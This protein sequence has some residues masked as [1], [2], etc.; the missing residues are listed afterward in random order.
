[1]N[2]QLDGHFRTLHL[3]LRGELVSPFHCHTYLD[4]RIGL[5]S[6]QLC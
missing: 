5:L 4:R 3:D 6:T 2:L 1:M